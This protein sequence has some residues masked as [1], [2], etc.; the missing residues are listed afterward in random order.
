MPKPFVSGCE[1]QQSRVGKAHALWSHSSGPVWHA[2]LRAAWRHFSN[3]LFLRNNTSIWGFIIVPLWSA[4]LLK[5]S[6]LGFCVS[7]LITHLKPSFVLEMA[8]VKDDKM[9]LGVLFL[10][11]S[12]VWSTMSDWRERECGRKVQGWQSINL[13]QYERW[14]ILVSSQKLRRDPFTLVFE[15]FAV[16]VRWSAPGN[17]W[18]LDREREEWQCGIS[19]KKAI[20]F[21]FQQ[22]FKSNSMLPLQQ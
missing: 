5:N 3:C 2:P 17:I 19:W 1:W 10:P 12:G 8:V 6:H 7:C 16:T 21:I 4:A 14:V 13:L 18:S 15:T 11:P 20:S 22:W 9:A